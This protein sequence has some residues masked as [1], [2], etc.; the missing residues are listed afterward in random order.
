MPR[1]ARMLLQ[2]EPA[3]YHV[4]R[5]GNHEQLV[6]YYP[7]VLGPACLAPVPDYVPLRIWMLQVGDLAPEQ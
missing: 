2:E 1:A 7:W 5:S 4:V 3:V 6:H